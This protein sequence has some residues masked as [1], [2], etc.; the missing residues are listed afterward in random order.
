MS[1]R[2]ALEGSLILLVLS[3]AGTLSFAEASPFPVLVLGIVC[4]HQAMRGWRPLLSRSGLN[5]AASGI[6]VFAL[7]DYTIL[8]SW[9]SLLTLGHVVVGMQAI[10]IYQGWRLGG[11]W[12]IVLLGFMEIV[13]A[14]AIMVS[15]SFILPFV[16]YLVFAVLVLSLYQIQDHS[17]QATTRW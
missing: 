8:N 12:R 4:L 5:L 3:G 16:T 17:I 9:D 1:D 2:R 11:V 10:R 6:L 13:V 7:I 15:G 14:A